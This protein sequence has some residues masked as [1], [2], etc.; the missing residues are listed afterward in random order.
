MKFLGTITTFVC[1]ALA[2]AIISARA[3]DNL[4]EPMADSE[5]I[6][7]LKKRFPDLQIDS[8]LSVGESEVI[9]YTAKWHMACN[10]KRKPKITFSKCRRVHA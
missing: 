4:G 7:A 8:D 5:V 2:A 3:A 10:L 1:L 6:T 9:F